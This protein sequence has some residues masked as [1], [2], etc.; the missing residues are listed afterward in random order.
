MSFYFDLTSIGKVYEAECINYSDSWLSG[1]FA[2]YDYWPLFISFAIIGLTLE[3][4]E[5]FYCLVLKGM[6]LNGLL[7]WGFREL[8]GQAGPE[9]GCS[10]STQNPAYAS[11]GL[12]FLFVTLLC[13]SSMIY[14]VPIRWFKLSILWIGGPLAI[15]TRVWL[16]FN[17][18]LQ[19]LSGVGFGLVE[20]ILYCLLL[21]FF[22]TYD[23]IDRWFL[24]GGTF[25]QG[26]RRHK[27]TP[28]SPH[29]SS[30]PSP[31]NGQRKTREHDRNSGRHTGRRHEEKD[32]TERER[33][34]LRGW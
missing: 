2:V 26:L 9:P 25:R 6:F 11:D 12:T 18:G 32:N 5:I 34:T 3:H 4:R 15:Y 28:Q 21:N 14:R 13:A 8:I 23:R 1:F 7:N 27:D 22:F 16:R 19:L 20:G 10:A 30:R 31:Q 29:Y 33:R 17:T 24:R